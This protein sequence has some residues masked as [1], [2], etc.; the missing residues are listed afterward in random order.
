MRAL[1]MMIQGT[2]SDAGKSTIAAALCRI[3]SED[4]WKTTP[5]KSQNMANNSY[6]TRD[7][8][9][10]G[11]AQGVQA[12][13]AGIDADTDMNPILIKPSGEARAQIVVHGKPLR[14]MEAGE[15]RQDYYETGLQ[16]IEAAYR[17]L[18][19]TYER[20]VIEGAGSPAEINLN[21]RELVNMKVAEI[22]DAPVILTADID[23]GGVF[24]NI[25]GTLQLLN[26]K[27]RTRIVGIII[28]KFRGDI[29]LLQPGLDW[30]EEYTGKPVLGV[31][32]FIEDL[33]IEE[34]DSLGIDRVRQK[35]SG[36]VIEIA[37]IAYPRV[38]NYTDIDPFLYEPD[39]NVRFVKERK[40]LGKPDIIILPGSKS[41]ISDLMYLKK[42]G[43][44]TALREAADASFIFGVCGG[45]QMLG[46]KVTDPGQ[47]E[48]S[49]KEIEGLGFF[50]T[51]QTEVEKEK[52]TIRTSGWL[53]WQGRMQ[54]VSGYEIHM[55][56]TKHAEASWMKKENG[57]AEGALNQKAAGTYMHDVFHNDKFRHALLNELRDIKGVPPIERPF[58]HEL[59]EASFSKLA[60]NFREHIDMEALEASITNFRQKGVDL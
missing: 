33:A 23:R 5:F 50:P 42:K 13:A 35:K 37:V 26:E 36:A 44:D 39:C 46:K 19:S 24:A 31:L 59:R 30:L 16:V 2:Q 11:R 22:A 14:T 34:E 10:I 48:S 43:F 9:E 8:K 51:M 49:V 6:I 3:F 40:E 38:S 53:Q 12:E 4:G 52:N 32:P 7:G 17:R 28:N 55:G 20:I 45:Y 60:D 56:T 15:Y 25:V 1:P 29:S 41:T 47:V 18:E 21:D 54:E 27:E 58:F 57:E